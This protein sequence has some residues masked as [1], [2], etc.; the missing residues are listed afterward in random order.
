MQHGIR[1]PRDGSNKRRTFAS[2]ISGK[3][4]GTSVGKWKNSFWSL[5]VTVKTAMS[6]V[7]DNFID[8]KD[9]RKEMLKRLEAHFEKWLNP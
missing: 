7:W 3:N 6:L 9:I 1:N 8:I 2:S 5:R 4:T